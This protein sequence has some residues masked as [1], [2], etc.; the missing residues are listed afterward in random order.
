MLARGLY[1]F[2]LWSDRRKPIAAVFA[3]DV[4]IDL[5]ETIDDALPIHAREYAL[6]VVLPHAATQ[7]CI[8]QQGRQGCGQSCCIAYWYSNATRVVDQTSKAAC[9][10]PYH[11]Q[12][13]A[14]RLDGGHAEGLTM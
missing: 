3:H 12:P 9:V 13:A 2:K 5:F 14:H 6:P 11:R 10:G 7:A 1:I 4:C 8:L